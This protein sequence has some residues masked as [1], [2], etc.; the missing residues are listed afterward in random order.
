M[1]PFD[2]SINPTA[3]DSDE[4]EMHNVYQNM[5]RGLIYPAPFARFSSFWTSLDG[6]SR[7]DAADLMRKTRAHLHKNFGSANTTATLGVSFS[8]YQNWCAQDGGSVPKGMDF[9]FPATASSVDKGKWKTSEV[10]ARSNGAF[11]DSSS[12]VWVYIKSDIEAHLAGAYEYV[13]EIMKAYEYQGFKPLYQDCNRRDTRDSTAGKVL[14]CR[15][16]ENLNNPADPITV[17]GH[18]LVGAED[19]EHMGGSFVLAQRFNVNWEQLHNMSEEQIEDL[20]GRTSDDVILPSRDTRT[21]IKSARFRDEFGNTR[22]IMRLG[23]PFG[24]SS[25]V[26]TD[27]LYKGSNIRDEQGIYFVGLTK[28]IKIL[29]GVMNQQIGD[30]E[31]FMNDRLFNHVRSDFGGFFYI[32]SRQDLGLEEM[33]WKGRSDKRW[34]RYPGVDWSK[35][36]RH[37]DDKSPNGRMYYNH[38]NYLYEMATMDADQRKKSMP[39]TNRILELLSDSFT[40]WQDSWYF[41]KGQAEM[42]HLCAY[43]AKDA[44][45]GP[46]VVREVMGASIAIR[47]AWAIRMTLRLYASESYGYRGR[48]IIDGVEQEGADTFRMNPKELIVGAMPDLTLAQGRFIMPYLRKEEEVGNYFRGLSEASGVGH[49]VPDFQK[50][51]DLGIGGLLEECDRYA[52][53]VTEKTKQDFYESCR[54]ALMGV[55]D[56][57]VAY[58]ALA[59]SRA[60]ALNESQVAD[61]ENLLEVA[62][63]LDKLTTEKPETMLEAVQLIFTVFTCLQLNAEPVALGRVDQYLAPFYAADLAAGRLTPNDGQEI[64]DAFWI[65]IDEKVLQNRMFVQDHQPF[66]NLAMGGASG[67]Y[68]QGASMG[69]WIQQLT[70]GGVVADDATE[71]TQAYN[72]VTIMCIRAS[73]RLPLNAP[74]LSLRVHKDTPREILEEAA[75]AILSGGAHPILMNDD[76]IIPG[77]QQSGVGI[78]EGGENAN[79]YTPVAVKAAGKWKSEVELASARNYACDGCY[80]PMFTGQNWFTLG[81]FSTLI[82]LEC[83]LN[84]G[85]LYGSAGPV[86]LQGQNQSFRSKAPAGIGQFKELVDLYLEH[87]YLL[88]AKAINGQ[89]STYDTL[90]SV[91]PS[92][93][94]STMIDDCLA[95]GLDL[96]G[97]GAKYNVYGPCF[98]ALSTTVNSLYNINQMVFEER[99]AVTSLPELVE[100]LM[101]DWGNKMEEPFI[102]S[103]VG[104]S[105][106]EGRAE[107]FRRLREVAL[108]YEKYGEGAARP[109]YLRPYDADDLGTYSVDELGN[110]LASEIARLTVKTFR[111]PF[112]QT[113]AQMLGYAEK[114]GTKE[115]PFGGFQIQPGA[116]TFENF[117]AF[118]GGSGASADG[119]RNN[120]SIA[121]DLSP[122][123]N[124][125]DRPAAHRSIDLKRALKSYEGEGAAAIWNGAPT[126]FNIPE[127]FPKEQL[128]DILS[129]FAKGSGSNILTVTCASPETMAAAPS[130]PERFDLLRVRMG[131]WTEFF[132]SMFPISQEQHLRRPMAEA[133]KSGGME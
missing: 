97:G 99:T 2:L 84:Q 87:F 54:I 89:L 55:Q 130:R 114:Y 125:G 104:P 25:F 126:D 108:T 80:E 59:R 118:G 117:V 32:P 30:T 18:S 116:G 68:P 66:G 73:A 7:K 100:C 93:L 133:D 110:Y 13:A 21:H 132:T 39:P 106:V 38:K 105:R 88:W 120:G 103:L 5:Q 35:L 67:P 85:R 22:F 127:D 96:Y 24:Q 62:G 10:F 56:H 79:D 31:G 45:F 37:F 107:R 129:D 101:C 9:A 61:R 29:E 91:C 20:I 92:P 102:S 16:S 86:F 123:P 52:K 124:S 76:K 113:A 121:S 60:A 4:Q 28:D 33:E 51:V 43:I 47:K 15:F 98:I 53:D 1:S 111:D 72:P 50:L 95:K 23:L 78:G 94:L 70:V 40:R 119:R 3:H 11:R 109:D 42:D 44:E 46:S 82:P 128:V 14:G 19:P 122:S 63:R 131:G 57:L 26:N 48:R 36:S 115:H 49:I 64:I 34:E 112:E 8:L 12:T 69:Q 41:P 90:A 77:L 75:A 83:A 71:A 27:L 17:A 65:K 58:A 6:F 74:C 81:G